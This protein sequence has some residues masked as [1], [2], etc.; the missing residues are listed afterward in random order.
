MG[1]KDQVSIPLWWQS[2]LLVLSGKIIK[3][4]LLVFSLTLTIYGH[5]IPPESFPSHWIKSFVFSEMCSQRPGPRDLRFTGK[6]QLD[7][8]HPSIWC[9]LGRKKKKQI[10]KKGLYAFLHMHMGFGK[11]CSEGPKLIFFYQQVI[12]LGQGHSQLIPVCLLQVRTYIHGNIKYYL[13]LI[14]WHSV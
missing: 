12:G 10:E 14:S 3:A 9:Q 4:C 1:A 6:F 5:T 8:L 2:S 7:L 11:S 13:A